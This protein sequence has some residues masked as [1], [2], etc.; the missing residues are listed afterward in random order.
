MD[1]IKQAPDADD[2]DEAALAEAVLIALK[3]GRVWLALRL[4]GKPEE[5]EE[6]C[7]AT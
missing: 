3:R 1:D 6:D 7:H 4:L 2:A 5:R